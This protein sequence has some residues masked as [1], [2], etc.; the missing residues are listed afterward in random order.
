MPPLNSLL[1]P[2][3]QA[4]PYPAISNFYCHILLSD[5][6]APSLPTMSYLHVCSITNYHIFLTCGLQHVLPYLSTNS[7]NYFHIFLSTKLLTTV[8]YSQ[9][10]HLH[11]TIS[12]YQLHHLL[13]YFPT[14][15]IIYFHVFLP[16]LSLTP[17]HCTVHPNSLLYPLPFCCTHNRK[18]IPVNKDRQR[19]EIKPFSDDRNKQNYIVV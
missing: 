4:L 5:Y 3:S 2:T 15:P 18:K 19:C 7:I 10:H 9:L 1:Y 12:L 16:T 13:P 14:N 6:C 8:S 17:I 11:T